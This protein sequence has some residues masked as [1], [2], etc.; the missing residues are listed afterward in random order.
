MKLIWKLVWIKFCI[1]NICLKWVFMKVTID[2]RNGVAC[3]ITF[4]IYVM[5]IEWKIIT[6]HHNVKIKLIV[7][8]WYQILFHYNKKKVINISHDWYWCWFPMLILL[9]ERRRWNQFRIKKKYKWGIFLTIIYSYT[10]VKMRE[11]RI[12]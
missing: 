10:V 4:F 8:V 5:V 12:T 11:N 9:S 2:K 7:I 3:Y 6:Y 1:C